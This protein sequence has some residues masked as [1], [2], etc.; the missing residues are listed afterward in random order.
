MQEITKQILL[1]DRERLQAFERVFH[2]PMPTVTPDGDIDGLP[3]PY[4]RMVHGVERSGYRLWDLARQ[5]KSTGIPVQNPI[6][7]RNT[8]EETLRE[9]REMYKAAEDLGL[10]LFHFVHSEATRH[11]D[12]LDGAELIEQSRG[13]GGITPMG[14]REYVAMGGGARHPMRIN[15][16]GDTPH[17]SVVNAFIAGL[18]GHR[19]GH[20][21]PFR[22]SRHSRLPD[23]SSQRLQDDA[24]L[25]REQ[26]FCPD[27][28][29]QTSEQ[30]RR[31]GRDGPGHVPAG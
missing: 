21:R 6:L 31:Y 17:L 5:A 26:N 22:R 30:Y 14:E 9:A 27:R 24:N 18:N 19:A 12:P 2:T 3:A 8:A 25:C 11:I 1:E 16:T 29:A 15:A 13:K 28:I 4:P 10:T 23:Q 20:S 7:G